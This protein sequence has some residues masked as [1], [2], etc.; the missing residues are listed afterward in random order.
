MPL[1]TPRL[2]PV[3]SAV[4]VS[5]MAVSCPRHQVWRTKGEYVNCRTRSPRWQI[6]ATFE[7][8][9]CCAKVSFMR[10]LISVCLMM[11]SFFAMAA[12]AQSLSNRR[13]PGFSL[14]D[15]SMKQHDLQDFRG[16]LVLLNIMQ[17]S[18]P[19]C[20]VFSKVLAE[21][22]K[23]Y[24]GQVQV[25]DIVNTP[26]ETQATVR[27]YLMRNG[28]SQ[29]VLFDCRQVSI[30]YLKLT[31][32]K[33]NFDVPHLFVIDQKGW[34]QADYGYDSDTTAIFEGEALFPIIEKYLPK[35]SAAGPKQGDTDRNGGF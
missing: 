28:V 32:E 18:C 2:A 13:A 14:P 19:H 1:P 21:A 7:G 23:R 33:P 29:L 35:A 10:R 31:P 9:S 34:I 17:T 22:E 20:N 6:D 8:R 11:V 27:N 3:T 12:S 16:K 24:K 4:G 26:P 25:I 30:S 5:N 15:M